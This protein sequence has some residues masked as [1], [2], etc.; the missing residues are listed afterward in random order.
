METEN[1]SEK[2]VIIWL[3]THRRVSEDRN[4]NAYRPENILNFFLSNAHSFTHVRMGM[5]LFIHY[6]FMCLIIQVWKN[7]TKT[8]EVQANQKQL[9]DHHVPDLRTLC[10][11]K[12]EY[13]FSQQTSIH[14][15]RRLPLV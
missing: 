7:G 11:N 8:V 12:Q 6:L 15:A 4:I 13:K 2:L 5:Y 3:T 10:C 9:V 1:S 14:Q